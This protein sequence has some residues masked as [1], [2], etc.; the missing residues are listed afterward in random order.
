MG[1]RFGAFGAARKRQNF[2]KIVPFSGKF[3]PAGEGFGGCLSGKRVIAILL[4][5][6]I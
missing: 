6:G 5:F 3:F 1:A 2:L 4:G